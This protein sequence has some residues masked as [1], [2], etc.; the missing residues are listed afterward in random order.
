[1]KNEKISHEEVVSLPDGCGLLNEQSRSRRSFLRSS[2]FLGGSAVVLSQ[3]QWAQELFA[4]GETGTGI[5][6]GDYDLGKP[7][8]ILSSVCLQ[9]NTGCGIKV[10]LLNG[11]AVKLEGN[12]YSPWTM[13]PSLPYKTPLKE[14]T[15]IYGSLCPKGQ[16]GIQTTRIREER[17][18]GESDASSP[19]A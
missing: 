7:E 15:S 12:P 9:C 3:L 5:T 2:A 14:T 13:V 18:H 1:M 6:P 16:A 4:K 11:V 10:K 17:R 19:A 8:N